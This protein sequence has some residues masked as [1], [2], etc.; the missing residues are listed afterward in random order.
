MVDTVLL[1]KV[2]QELQ[3]NEQSTRA[4]KLIFC[5]CKKYWENDNNVLDTFALKYLLE[6]IIELHNNRQQLRYSIFQVVSLLNRKDLYTSVSNLII[7]VLSPCYQQSEEITGFLFPPVLPKNSSQNIL[8][9]V[10]ER[11]E[12]DRNAVRI[13]KIVLYV[14]RQ[15]W[16]NDPLILDSFDFHELIKDLRKKY[17]TLDEVENGIFTVVNTLNRKDVY[18]VV[19]KT[20]INEVESLYSLQKAPGRGITNAQRTKA[21]RTSASINKETVMSGDLPIDYGAPTV[22]TKTKTKQKRRPD[23][24]FQTY[25]VEDPQIE[26]EPITDDNENLEIDK[27]YDI[28][29]IRQE[30]MKYANPLRAK[31]LLFSVVHHK[32]DNNGKDWSLLNTCILD[33]L[34]YKAYQKY[35][36]LDL[37]EE[38]IY[39]AATTLNDPE[40]YLQSAQAIIQALKSS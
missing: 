27:N 34:M 8:D 37:L 4:K 7:N 11:L 31:I 6:E 1:D 19:A 30:L 9:Q 18:S 35:K 13:K 22:K 24:S 15:K 26:D 16:V 17:P 39:Q 36:N 23:A 38:K 14:C 2:S 5:V 40:E 12:G 28:F 20:I 3:Q 33:D 21:R 32:F 25:I 10:V 29:S